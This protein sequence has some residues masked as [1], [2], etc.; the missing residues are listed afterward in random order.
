VIIYGTGT[1]PLYVLANRLLTHSLE[2]FTNMWSINW[3]LTI[4]ADILYS[5]A[6][7]G[8]DVTVIL[9]GVDGRT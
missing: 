5:V 8:T 3:V 4:I 1:L 7:L 9:D 6:F 2:D